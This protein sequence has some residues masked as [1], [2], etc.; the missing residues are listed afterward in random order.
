MI[1]KEVGDWYEQAP[2]VQVE[3]A[4][5]YCSEDHFWYGP[6][7]N[8]GQV[9]RFACDAAPADCPDHDAFM[10]CSTSGAAF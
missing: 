1:D 4:K 9:Q 5:F 8:I 10:G 6:S 3:W 2:G 7:F